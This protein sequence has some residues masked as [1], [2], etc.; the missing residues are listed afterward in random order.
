MILSTWNERKYDVIV[1]GAGS[2]GCAAAWGA[3]RTG[4]RTLLVERLG[5]PGGTPVASAIHTLDA[6][7]SCRDHSQPVVGGFAAA[8]IEELRRIGGLACADN[9]PEAFSVNAEHMKVAIG[10]LFQSTGVELLYHALAIDAVRRGAAVE[11]V[12]AALLD[13]RSRLLAHTVID[14][15]GDA[16]IAWFAG[17]EW[18]MSDDLQSITYH[19]RLGNVEPGHTWTELEEACRAAMHRLA[20]PH[21][22]YGGPWVIR[23]H[24]REV[25][26]NATRVYGNPLDPAGRTSMEQRARED[27]LQVAAILRAGVP[28]LAESYVLAGATDLHVRESRKIV[29]DYIFSGDDLRVRR[30]FDDAIAV[31]AWPIDI[32]PSDGFSGVHPHKENPPE[33][34]QLP[35]R[36]LLPRGIEGLLVAGKPISTTHE[37]HG[38]TRIPGTSMATGHAAGVA[39]A[40]ASRAGVTPRSVDVPQLRATLLAQGAILDEAPVPR[41]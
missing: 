34:Y 24:E 38:S 33:P 13:G 19:F 22:V 2:A 7:Y 30:T 16:Q 25:S 26:I 1:C 15:T 14:C 10:R 37:A 11:G 28:A 5:F 36:C 4:A 23:L 6:V 31:G 9:P 27:M 32:H 18:Q 41:P 21:L 40:L 8:L 39:A 29:G 17:A 3:A 35:Y 20:P 12:E